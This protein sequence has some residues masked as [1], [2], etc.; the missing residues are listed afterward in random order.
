MVNKVFLKS[1]LKYPNPTT[2][3]SKTQQ[4]GHKNKPTLAAEPSHPRVDRCTRLT[5]AFICALRSIYEGGVE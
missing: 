3:R 2:T 4:S 1:K 5:G